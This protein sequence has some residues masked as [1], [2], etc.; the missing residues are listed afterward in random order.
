MRRNEQADKKLSKW[1]SKILRHAPDKY[2]IVL[3]E[4]GSCSVEELLRVLLRADH[5]NHLTLA[6]IERIVRESDKQRFEMK[7]G[8]IRARYGHSYSRVSYPAAVP[9]PVLYHGTNQT[10]A[11]AILESGIQ[12]M[13][14]QYVHLSAGLSFARLAG[15]RRGQLVILQVDTVKAASMGITFYY[16]GNEVWLAD[17]IPAACCSV[18]KQGGNS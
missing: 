14:R 9:P 13:G 4:D 12:S 6:D 16:A 8:R 2:G 18:F 10:A 1:M 7:D 17:H 3:A 11:P 15:E 5:W